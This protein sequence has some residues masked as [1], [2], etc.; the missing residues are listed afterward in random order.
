[1]TLKNS[2]VPGR[3]ALNVLAGGTTRAV[4][5]LGLAVGVAA[6]AD[7]RCLARRQG[8]REAEPSVLNLWGGLDDMR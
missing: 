8:R 6:A 4:Y 1:M 3:V 2:Q 5:T 7:P